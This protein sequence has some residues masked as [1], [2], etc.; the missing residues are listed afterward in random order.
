MN[1][2]GS[3][4]ATLSLTDGGVVLGDEEQEFVL[5]GSQFKCIIEIH[6]AQNRI[7][8]TQSHRPALTVHDERNGIVGEF[9][10]LKILRQNLDITHFG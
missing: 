3:R 2:R 9:G 6:A 5:S 7:A 4:S 8:L 1:K 10:I